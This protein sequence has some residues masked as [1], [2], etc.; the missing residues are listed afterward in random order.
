MVLGV[1]EGYKW[2]LV[3]IGIGYKVEVVGNK[4]IFSFGFSYLV[5][6]VLFKGIMVQLDKCG[7]KIDL[8]FVDK[9]FFGLYVFQIC[10]YCLLE[11]Y[12]GKGV[13]YLDEVIWC[14]V[15]KIGKQG[16][17][18]WLRQIELLDCVCVVRFMFVSM[19]MGV[20][21]VYG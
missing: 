10:V 9:E 8:E 21:C 4:L 18:G 20:L 17:R 6:Y 19:L 13:V 2:F 15:G 5:V 16:K 14:K 3:I 11:L 1:T 7:L 12:K